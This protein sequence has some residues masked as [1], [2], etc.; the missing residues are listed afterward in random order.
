MEEEREKN[1]RELTIKAIVKCD[2]SLSAFKC[3][4][5]HHV[6]SKF[7]FLAICL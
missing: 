1:T 6:I 5:S 7:I 2:D 4:L 3:L